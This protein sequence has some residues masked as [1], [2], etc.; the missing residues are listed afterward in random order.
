MAEVERTPEG[1]PQESSAASRRPPLLALILLLAVVAV[2]VYIGTNVL[3]VLFAVIAPPAPPMPSNMV[4]ATH[5][6]DGYGVDRWTYT[7][8]G[9]ACQLV[10]YILDNGGVCHVAPMQCGEYRELHEDFT[11]VDSVVARCD[12]QIPFSIFNQQWWAI[13][14][15]QP[16]D[17]IQLEVNR[18]IFWI[19]TGPQ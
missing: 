2:A 12:G 1:T 19:G 15:R 7:S 17:K 18:E 8:T 13:V 14:T 6:S 3:T 10:Q 5:V 11:I 4:E 16:P 9:D